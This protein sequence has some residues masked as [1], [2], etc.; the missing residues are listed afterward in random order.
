MGG[1][2]GLGEEIRRQIQA[3]EFDYQSLLD[4]LKDYARP[5]DKITGLL[6]CGDI[7]R[8]KKGLYVF[9]GKYRRQPFSRE[10]LANLIYGP[11]YISLEYALH[12]HGL[13]PE[14]A[15][16]V[17]SVTSGRSHR[18]LT[19]VGLFAYWGI[20]LA[21]FRLGMDQYDMGDG[22]Y[23][24]MAGP[25]KSLCDKIQQDRGAT[26]GAQGELHEYLTGQ[27]RINVEAL[28][29]LDPGRIEE[30]SRGYRSRKLAGLALWISQLRRD[31]LG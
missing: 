3:E 24:L 25:E 11:S 21:A 27:L 8:V 17:T 15:E 20:P 4:S 30:F 14:R 1:G 18:F 7:I 19:P 2:I 6:R 13:I 31:G 29:A 16:A 9:G 5:R 23:F 10:L 26:G 28:A 12:Y 22:R